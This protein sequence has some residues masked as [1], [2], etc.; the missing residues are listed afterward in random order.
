MILY[1]KWREWHALC[2]GLKVW[3]ERDHD[4]PQTVRFIMEVLTFIMKNIEPLDH[5]PPAESEGRVI[6]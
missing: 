6:L 1:G 5:K 2:I 4:N 3:A